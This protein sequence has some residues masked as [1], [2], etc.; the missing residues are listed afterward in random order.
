MKP[1]YL[2]CCILFLSLVG[3]IAQETQSSKVYMNLPGTKDKIDTEDIIQ[4][5]LL[6]KKLPIQKKE[7]ENQD[8][9]TENDIIKDLSKYLRD[10]DEKSRNLYDFKSP[11]RDMIGTSSDPG[12]LEVMA[13]RKAKKDNYKITVMQ[14]AKP[15]SFMSSSIPR[16][17]VLPAGDFKIIV[18]NNTFS[19]K[20]PGGSLFQ[21]AEAI[22]EQAGEKIDVRII[23]DTDTTSIMVL[24]GKETGE[25]N[26]IRFEGNAQLLL[27]IGLLVK[28]EPKTEKHFVDFTKIISR[29]GNKINSDSRSVQLKPSDEGEVPLIDEN[30]Q[31][32]ENTSLFFN[33]RLNIYSLMEMENKDRLSNVE[34]SKMEPVTISNV[35]VHGGNLITFYEEQKELPAIVS[36]FTEILTIHFKDGTIKTYFI[37]SSGSFSNDLTTYKGKTIERI[38]VQNKNTDR[39]IILSDVAFV[40]KIS[41]EGLQPKNVISKACDAIIN[42]DGVEIRRDNNNIDDLVEGVTFSL[43]NES[44]DK[45]SVTVDHDYKKVEDSILA[46][47]DSYNKA[48]EYLTILTKPNQDRT[49]LSQRSQETLKE[50]V[51]QTESAF[52]IMKNKLRNIP[53]DPYKTVYG[54][55]LCLLEQSGI[56]TKKVGT[57]NANSDEWTSAKMGLLNIDLDKFKTILK[58]KFDGVEQLFASDSEGDNIKDSGVAVSVNKTLRMGLGA[59]GFIERRIAINEDKIKNNQKEIEKMNRDLVSYELE[60]RKKFGKMNKVLSETESK[61]KWMNAQMKSQQED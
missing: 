48:M 38:S 55:E 30:I 22:R 27:D 61:K 51:F 19:I 57:F 39:D 5:L 53:M 8:Y 15:D 20:F 41:E 43:K 17:K 14:T 46:W 4:K 34:I 33:A 49:P 24:S 3:G 9:K 32:K 42:F 45:V 18:G 59:G 21:L 31:I 23:N 6:I 40:T 36:N 58:E 13:S 28:S 52:I 12:I 16:N 10:L 50:G 60:Q 37:D 7:S 47:I 44:K 11:F 35:T 29:T 1:Y 54:K 25:K 26:K 56:Y 2:F